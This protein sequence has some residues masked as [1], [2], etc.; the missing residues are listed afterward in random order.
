MKSYNMWHFLHIFYTFFDTFV[1]WTDN[2]FY[3]K[4]YYNIQALYAIAGTSTGEDG[5]NAA[6]MPHIKYTEPLI[7]FTVPPP[8]LYEQGFQA[9]VHVKSFHS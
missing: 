4:I 8:K 6:Q 1:N 7:D 5:M 2:I 3:V 9:N